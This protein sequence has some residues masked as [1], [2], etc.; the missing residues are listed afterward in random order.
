MKYCNLKYSLFKSLW[1]I[2]ILCC[3]ANMHAAITIDSVK[4]TISRC[5]N[6]GTIT[7]FA[8]SNQSSILY[9]ILS[10]PEIRPY[11]S[12]N[13]FNGLFPGTYVVSA[14]NVTGEKDSQ[15]VIVKGSNYVEPDFAP[16]SK[17]PTC[18][19]GSDGQIIGRPILSN[20]RPPFTWVLTNTQTNVV[21]TQSNDTFNNL[22][23][24]TYTLRM[25]DSCQNFVTRTIFINNDDTIFKEINIFP[26]IKISKIG[27][28]TM[29]LNFYF[30]TSNQ[31]YTGTYKLTMHSNNDTIIKFVKPK[32]YGT[33]YPFSG[34]STYEIVDTFPDVNYGEDFHYILEDNCGKKIFSKEKRIA[35]F[36]FTVYLWYNDTTDCTGNLGAILDIYH[37]KVRFED[38]Y[39]VIPKYPLTMTVKDIVT[40]T[41][42]QTS[43]INNGYLNI[44]PKIAGRNYLITIS[45]ACGDIYA[46][47]TIWPVPGKP[48]VS[49]L[50]TTGCIDST[51]TVIL[52][53][54]GFSKGL[55]L[56]IISGTKFLESTKPNYSYFDSIKYPKIYTKFESYTV[57]AG[58]INVTLLFRLFLKNVPAGTYHYK[59]SDSCG[60]EIIDSF[61][62][63]VPDL[64]ILNHQTY[65][66]R[67]CL[68]QNILYYKLNCKKSYRKYITLKNLTT[69]TTL[70][71]LNLTDD[72]IFDSITS[73]PSAKYEVTISY[74]IYATAINEN[75]KD[76]WTVK[77]TV[78]I[79][80]YERP[81]T[82]SVSTIYCNG[83]RYAE[84]HPDSTKGIAPYQ[85]EV[86]S[87]PRLYPLQASN[88]FTFIPVGNYVS[89]I[90]DACGN[91]N[92]LD[93]GIDTLIFPPINK[94][95]S[96][97]LNGS[98]TLYYQ[99]SPFYTYQWTK[100]NGSVYIGD[101]LTINGV[102]Y[103]DTG[104]YQIKRFVNINGCKDT[105]E[106]TYRLTSTTEYTRDAR[107]CEGESI[108]VGTHT[109]TQ[110]GTYS[111]TI[112]SIFCDT[113]YT[114]NLTVL[115]ILRKTI[116]TTICFG[117]GI[118]IGN[119]FYNQT[120]T[121]VDT[122]VSINACDSIIT[123]KLTITQ[124][125]TLQITAS[126]TI[127]F[128]G[129]TVQLHAISTQPIGS[130][131]WTS[132]A[133]LNNNT[134]QNPIATIT[135]PSWIYLNVTGDSLFRG[136][137]NNDS[138]FIDLIKDCKAENVFIPN[139]FSPNNDGYNDVFKV[140]SSTLL[141]GTLL[142]YDRWGNKV[143]ESDDLSK[144][145]NGTYKG[146]PAQVE[147]YGYYFEGKCLNEESIILKGNVTLLR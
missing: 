9:S 43:Q 134:I 66:K 77:D 111:D 126:K 114:L 141:S 70:L 107:I 116:D 125:I 14:T 12:G 1:M 39:A 8:S 93:F 68:G 42:V 89:R 62:V 48:L 33:N 26:N 23:A 96:S 121:Y 84:L 143:F 3:S 65:F 22:K 108:T 13:L 137:K 124:G 7:V 16:T 61:V 135:Q 113:I 46:F 146:Q 21:T 130:Y 100:P 55:K 110:T 52:D 6:N 136:C 32:I 10:G 49:Y 51:T 112:T 144:G 127:V 131:I 78:E 73:I 30:Y 145:W 122:L 56:E 88:L 67:G 91:S 11:Q 18:Y 63:R 128:P 28:D 119:H 85:Y 106:T 17:E 142:I 47:D 98:V 60:N 19:G 74:Y 101:S 27:C 87:G 132:I 102:V 139:A 123:L 57:S 109:Y 29:R 97:C 115:P 25:Y 82:A 50:R 35:P 80:P 69:N 133:T 41:V 36:M 147:V 105:A 45:D 34:V 24:S 75:I 138:I 86:I 15:T 129:D 54:Y 95:G 83:N 99:P 4:T 20:S 94:N 120:G 2:L 90:V 72:N 92:I 31:N 5:P 79:P 53:L 38:Y 40:N 59:V 103:A 118:Q 117:K 76:C 140:R 58:N 71:S 37:N 44:T 81:Q 64:T 104:L